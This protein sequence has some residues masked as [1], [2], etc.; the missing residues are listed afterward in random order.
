MDIANESPRA[1]VSVAI[2][3]DVPLPVAPNGRNP[4]MVVKSV[5]SAVA[6][7]TLLACQICC[8]VCD[9]ES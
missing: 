8:H 7:W 4:Q 5:V 6:E 9:G 2:V 1:A 3:A